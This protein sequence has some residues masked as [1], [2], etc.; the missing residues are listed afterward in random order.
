LRRAITSTRRRSEEA[1]RASRFIGGRTRRVANL[2]ES[3]AKVGRS[4][5]LAARLRDEEALLSRL[6]NERT[7]VS[8][9][10]TRAV[11]HPTAAGYL[12]NLFALLETDPVR[13]R[14]TL[15]RRQLPGCS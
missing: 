14:E 4:E 8:K 5:A 10:V 12:K 2:T 1:A 15:S 6:K 11:P 3:L 13:G 7:A 9:E